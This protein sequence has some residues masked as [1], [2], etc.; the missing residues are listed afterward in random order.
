MNNLD[1][2]Y[3]TAEDGKRHRLNYGTSSKD[4][5]INIVGV[6]IPGRAKID[7]CEA[8]RGATKCACN[9]W[10][11][12]VVTKDDHLDF[13][14]CINIPWL[15]P[16]DHDYLRKKVLEIDQVPEI[17][18]EN[19]VTKSYKPTIRMKTLE[20]LEHDGIKAELD[21]IVIRYRRRAGTRLL[22]ATGLETSTYL[23]AAGGLETSKHR[24][25]KSARLYITTDNLEHATPSNRQKVSAKCTVV[26]CSIPTELGMLP[27][28]KTEIFEYDPE[29]DCLLKD[30]QRVAIKNSDEMN[31]WIQNVIQKWVEGAE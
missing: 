29:N 10:K 26:D 1:D 31:K 9:V 23:L 5:I 12:Q 22:A 11:H 20:H 4:D 27:S 3:I 21:R 24:I 18:M 2:V 16:V 25:V 19:C 7:I 14:L 6:D 8:I 17:E 28:P 30:G 13:M 15:T